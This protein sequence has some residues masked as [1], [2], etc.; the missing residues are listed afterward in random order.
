[1]Y[2]QLGEPVHVPFKSGHDIQE[3]NWDLVPESLS[4]K[5]SP[6]GRVWILRL[7]DPEFEALTSR[8]LDSDS[9]SYFYY[10]SV[11]SVR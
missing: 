7:S 6:Y 1:M 5:C 4:R 11:S 8:S 9:F 10:I 2:L 3:P